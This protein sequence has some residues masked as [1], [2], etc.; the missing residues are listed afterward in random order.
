[1]SSPVDEQRSSFPVPGFSLQW[2]ALQYVLDEL[3]VADRDAFEARLASDLSACEAVAAASRFVLTSRAAF[4]EPAANSHA[5]SA[6]MPYA[7]GPL[8]V[9]PAPEPAGRRMVTGSSINSW[10]AVVST[11]AAMAMLLLFAIQAPQS[12]QSDT[13]V[14]QSNST[15][16]HS[17]STDIDSRAAELV[18]LWRSG[19][20]ASDDDADDLEELADISSDVAV[21]GWLLAAVSFETPGPVE[22]SLEKL[23]E[24]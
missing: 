8:A 4:R 10:L 21:P 24:N 12:P 3:S 11:S 7:T 13:E 2:L 9:L 16:S 1:M 5:A 20:D 18:S 17:K 23:Q 15:R 22:G 19:M 14:A 6:P